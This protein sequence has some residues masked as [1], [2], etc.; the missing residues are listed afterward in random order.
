[1]NA[2]KNRLIHIFLDENNNFS[3]LKVDGHPPKKNSHLNVFSYDYSWSDYTKDISDQKRLFENYNDQFVV[4]G[5]IYSSPYVNESQG[6]LS[7]SEILMNEYLTKKEKVFDAIDGDF[8][9]IH[10]DKKNRKVRLIRDKMG[11]KALFYCKK[12]NSVSFSSDIRYLIQSKISDRK[13]SLKGV[14]NYLSFPSPT[15]PI[16]MYSDIDALEKSHYLSIDNNEI[17]SR[18]YAQLPSYST[19]I[20]ELEP[21][22]ESILSTLR[23]SIDHTFKLHNSH[24]IGSLISGGVDSSLIVALL[25]E[26]TRSFPSITISYKGDQEIE[27]GNEESIAKITTSRYNLPHIIKYID[28]EILA[29]H[30]EN[31]IDL[32]EQAGNQFTPYYLSNLES[33]DNNINVLYSG[34]GADE[35]HGGFYYF[36]YIK[37]WRL[38]QNFPHLLDYLNNKVN[39]HKLSLICKMSKARD[40]SEYYTQGFSSFTEDQKKNILSADEDFNS[41]GTIKE[42]YG[43]PHG[44]NIDDINALL[45]YMISNA[46]NQHLY[47]FGLFARY[48]DIKTIYPYL[49][50]EHVKVANSIAPALKVKWTKRK[51]ALKHA[52]KELIPLEAINQYKLGLVTPRSF[53]YANSFK[54]RTADMLKYLE[55][56]PYFSNDL[57]ANFYNKPGKIKQMVKLVD[58][59]NWYRYHINS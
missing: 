6:L 55:E 9:I 43:K 1:M 28:E 20:R 16:T 45:Y 42:V 34:L 25:S 37:L 26:K 21:A 58:L 19:Q 14:W 17:E 39:N 4:L 51:I 31:I 22:K 8:I 10:W 35:L 7:T 33:K 49:N 54:D 5:S 15:Q 3:A 52:A 56:I 48:F 18:P 57:Y 41:F 11:I 32:N 23:D 40:V 29:Q 24:S 12:G 50:Q 53:Y 2:S 44:K 27:K 46:Q 38:V 47:K 36:Q 59:A 30:I 13:P